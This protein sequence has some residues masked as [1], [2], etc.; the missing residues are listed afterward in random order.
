MPKTRVTATMETVARKGKLSQSKTKASSSRKLELEKMKPMTT[1]TMIRPKICFCQIERN[2]IPKIETKT[3][4][5]TAK[6]ANSKG[7]MPIT[8]IRATEA[9]V[10]N[11]PKTTKT[12]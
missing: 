6:N 9:K 5:K 7:R 4:A 10:S 2:A 3:A 1:S 12:M 8:V 11:T